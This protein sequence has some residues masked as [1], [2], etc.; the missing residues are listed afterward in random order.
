[1]A[2]ERGSFERARRHEPIIKWNNNKIRQKARTLGKQE[3][4]YSINQRN[5]I[6]KKMRWWFAP[7]RDVV[8]F[9][10]YLPHSPFYYNCTPG[11]GN[12]TWREKKVF[13]CTRKDLVFIHCS[14]IKLLPEMK[15]NLLLKYM[16]K[17]PL[18]VCI[19]QVQTWA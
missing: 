11:N 19:G 2:M 4:N 14:H 15:K 18:F 7:H 5:R 16:T 3:E 10:V 17:G 12:E 13:N 6:H 1:M 9:L 8:G